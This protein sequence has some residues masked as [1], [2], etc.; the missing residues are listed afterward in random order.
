MDKYDEIFFQYFTIESFDGDEEKME[1][2]RK[3]FNDL[4]VRYE[5]MNIDNSLIDEINQ[6]INDKDVGD[7]IVNE[8][9]YIS[10]KN[11][12]DGIG[13]KFHDIEILSDVDDEDYDGDDILINEF[14]SNDKGYMMQESY[15]LS[16]KIFGIKKEEIRTK[17]INK[18]AQN[19][20]LNY[21]KH[22]TYIECMSM[23]N[24]KQYYKLLLEDAISSE[25]YEEA[26]TLRDRLKEILNT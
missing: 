20:L 16:E 12:L 14:W 22:S 18:L 7:F 15:Y 3:V 26:A 21:E 2:A 5:E 25:N 19:N 24:R 4:M 1:V 11:N 6:R 17:I 10:L 8:E 13:L 23:E 9:E